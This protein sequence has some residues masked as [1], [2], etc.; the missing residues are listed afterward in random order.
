MAVVRGPVGVVRGSVA[1]PTLP[2][3]RLLKAKP[4]VP[5]IF[6]PAPAPFP[7]TAGSLCWGVGYDGMWQPGWQ[8]SLALHFLLGCPQD[9][10]WET[11]SDSHQHLGLA[12]AVAGLHGKQGQAGLYLFR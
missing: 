12:L 2:A 4:A 6:V 11:G 10:L 9:S 8:G 7:H 3:P 5:P 1:A